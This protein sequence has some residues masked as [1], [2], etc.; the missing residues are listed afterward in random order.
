MSRNVRYALIIL[1]L[2]LIW[3]LSGFFT[4][5]DESKGGDAQT[6]PLTQVEVMN[7][8]AELYQPALTFNAR[9]A[10]FRLVS[11]RAETEGPLISTDV[12]EGLQVRKSVVVGR[13]DPESRPLRVQEARS[14][15]KQ[16]Q[17]EYEGAL[18]L[19]T[20]GLLSD[21][22]VARNKFA[23]DSAKAALDAA[24]IELSRSDIRAPFDG[25]LNERFYEVGDYIQKGQIFAEFLQ[26]DPLKAIF[27]VSNA[28]VMALDPDQPL[29]LI[30][31]DGRK[32]VGN[33]LFRSAKADP[34]SRAFKVE[35]VF[36]NP[37]SSILADLTGRVSVS[38]QS[39]K[40]HVIPASVLSLDTQGELMVKAVNADQVVMSYPVEILADMADSVWISGLPETVDVIVTGY[41]YVGL[42]EKV[43]VS[44]R[45]R[46]VAEKA[47]AGFM[48]ESAA[49]EGSE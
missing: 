9:T 29:T 6:S 5:D 46:Q 40:A 33:L 32:L 27:Q 49:L 30:L 24:Q 15:L 26:L 28:E 12:A 1:A 22:E 23:V 42:G 14:R 19:K 17:L 8:V 35:A 3:L 45:E 43:R 47:D 20:K 21:A 37:D 13:I 25:V 48:A 10:P 34:Q 16:T 41:E 2:I 18:E 7:S 39:V 38:L 31:S 4:S 44:Y 11:L 36:D